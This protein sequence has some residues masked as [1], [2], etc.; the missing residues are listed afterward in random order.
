M[1][2]WDD[3][4]WWRAYTAPPA[5]AVAGGVGVAKPGDVVGAEARAIVDEVHARCTQAIA[6]RAR[7]YARKGQVVGVA[8]SDR[9]AVAQIQGSDALPYDVSLAARPSKGIVARC[10]CPYGCTPSGWCKHAGALGYVLADLVDRD[11]SA[12]QRWSGVGTGAGSSVER[13]APIPP[14]LLERLQQPLDPP[15]LTAI[16]AEA[17]LVAP[18][19]DGGGDDPVDRRGVSG[20]RAR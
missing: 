3:Q 16:L 7:T 2:R 13:A 18:L 14:E 20:S 17:A 9:A 19:P 5:R 12:R 8:V 11:A 6:A 1:G 15:D 10:D 4:P